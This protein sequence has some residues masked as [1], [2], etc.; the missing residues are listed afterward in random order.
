MTMVSI[1][2]SAGW[3]ATL[4]LIGAIGGSTVTRDVHAD[5]RCKHV[6]GTIHSL[7][8]STGCTSPVGLCTAGAITGSGELD[9]ATTFLAFDAAPSAGLPA[10]E[11]AANLSYSGA[12]TINARRGTLLTHDLGVLDATGLAFT[13]IERPASGTGIFE[14]P[15]NDFFIS[16]AI[17]D[18][19]NGFT[20]EI[21]GILCSD[22]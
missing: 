3:V 20:G 7:F 15:S 14:N 1:S 16:G 19:G 4:C 9:G 17:T 13:E 6:S 5:E 12:L 21:Y 2:K 8:S 10:V 11:P 22:R 18:S